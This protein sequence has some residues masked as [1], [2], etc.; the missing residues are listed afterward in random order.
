MSDS[1][2]RTAEST[3]KKQVYLRK[4]IMEAGYDPSHFADF[5]SEQ[6]EEGEDID[7][8]SLDSLKEMVDKYIRKT[9]KPSANIDSDEEEE[10][11]PKKLQTPKHQESSDEDSDADDDPLTESPQK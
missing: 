8:W 1:E 6:R 2:E 10:E 4:N 9:G 11:L 7:N 5:M 3:K